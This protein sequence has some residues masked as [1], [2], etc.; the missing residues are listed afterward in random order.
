MKKCIKCGESN[1]NDALFCTN[2]GH[3]LEDSVIVKEPAQESSFI[4]YIYKFIGSDSND[5][6]DWHVLFSDIF[7]EHTNEE[8]EKIFTCGTS[9]TTPDPST[10]SSDFPKPWLY[11]RIFLGMF[12]TFVLLWICC[13]AFGNVNALPGMI[14]V[15]SFIVPLTTMMLFFEIN[16]WRNISF[17][18]VL[19]TFMLGGCASLLATLTLFNIIPVGEL[20]YVGA[21]LVG[22]IEEIGK[23]LIVYFYVKRTAK[24]TILTGLLYGACVGAGFAAFESAGYAFNVLLS[25]GFEGMIHNIFLRGFLA[26]GGHVAWAAISG[27][28]IVMASKKMKSLSVSEIATNPIFIRLFSI[29]VFMHAL[30][31]CPISRFILP[32]IYGLHIGL[33]IFVWIVLLVMINLGLNEISINKS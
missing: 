1:R 17:F 27:A 13:S 9:F 20:D 24:P 14:V 18:N 16:V 19:K 5:Q 3:R 8:A 2:C 30:W 22:L 6:V 10:L 7:K 21:F 29:P 26:P 25:S 23:A 28:A 33:V 4:Q 32:N 15:G 11:A 12:I 31:D